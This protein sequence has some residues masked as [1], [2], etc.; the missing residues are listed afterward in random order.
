MSLGAHLVELRR[1]LMI[2]AIALVVGMVLAFIVADPIIHFITEP[3]RLITEKRGDDFS[4][5]NFSTVTSAF[6][7]RMRIALSI[8][9]FAS[10]PVWLWQIWA[11]IMPGLTRKEV[12]YTV[13]FVAAAVPLFLGGCYLGVMIMPHII[14]LMWSFTPE[15]GTNFYAAQDYY[16]FIF[17]LMLVIGVSFVLPVFL[18]ALNFA[19]IMSGRAILK[20]WRVAIIIATVFAALATPAADVVSMLMLAG[21]LIVLYFAAAGLSLLF[22]RRKRKQDAAAGLLP[23]AA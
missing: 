11:F 20:G 21:I 6:D 14:E 23:D 2:A 5:L 13:G 19:G 12:R 10:A 18:V 4:A 7:M 1:R 16:D 22:D 17:K 15:G 9:L 8:G 3:I